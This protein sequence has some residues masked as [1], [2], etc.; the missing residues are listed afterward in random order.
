[1]P[2]S[3]ASG[4]ILVRC[5]EQNDSKEGIGWLKIVFALA[6]AIDASLVAWLAQNHDSAGRLVVIV[7]SIAASAFA[8]V[9][10]VVNYEAYRRIKDL[11]NL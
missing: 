7:A 5:R 4:I 6:A 10:V 2:G 1:M 8:G 9:V 11:E 3:D